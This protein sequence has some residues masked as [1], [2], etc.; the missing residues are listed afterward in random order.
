MHDL[1]RLYAWR[2]SDT[3]ADADGREQARDRLLG[4]YLCRADA[5]E[6]PARDCANKPPVGGGSARSRLTWRGDERQRQP[7]TASAGAYTIRP[8]TALG[9]CAWPP[10]SGLLRGPGPLQIL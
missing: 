3:Y 2:L 4:F 6:A 5:A 7:S 1:L 9:P 10:T 8:A